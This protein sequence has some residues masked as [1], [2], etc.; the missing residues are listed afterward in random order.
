MQSASEEKLQWMMETREREKNWHSSLPRIAA[1]VSRHDFFTNSSRRMARTK[2]EGNESRS[3]QRTA[4]CSSKSQSKR[5][6]RTRAGLG[7][8]EPLRKTLRP[9]S[10][11]GRNAANGKT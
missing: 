3:Y 9:T 11:Y 2:E 10:E 7:Y 8:F 4:E 6:I 5:F 1:T